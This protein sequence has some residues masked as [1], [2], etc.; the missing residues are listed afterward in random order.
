MAMG[1]GFDWAWSGL[2][3]V[4]VGLG[5]ARLRVLEPIPNTGTNHVNFVVWPELSRLIY[6]LFALNGMPNRVRH[7][8]YFF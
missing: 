5:W 6:P 8:R 1:Y 2:G 7:S 4:F 3:L